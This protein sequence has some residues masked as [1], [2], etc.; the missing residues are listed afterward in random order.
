MSLMLVGVGRICS[1][2]KVYAML[3]WK[4]L[5]ASRVAV[6]GVSMVRSICGWPLS[7]IVRIPGEFLKNLC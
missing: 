7:V 5:T 1:S 3:R 6:M 2:L 4:S